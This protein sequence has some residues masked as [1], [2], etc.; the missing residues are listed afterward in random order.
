MRFVRCVRY[1]KVMRRLRH[2]HLVNYVD[3]FLVSGDR[4]LWVVMEYLEGG[5][6]TDVV[7]ETVLSNAQ[8]AAVTKCCL[9]ALAFLHSHV[10]TCVVSSA[11]KLKV[12]TERRD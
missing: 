1:V 8:I 4:E 12:R 11:T 9:Q 3:S 5:A 7:V 6:L 2:D 10:R